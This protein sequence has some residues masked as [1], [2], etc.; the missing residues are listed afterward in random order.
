MLGRVRV[1]GRVRLLRRVVVETVVLLR[2]TGILRC[3]IRIGRGMIALVPAL[4]VSVVDSRRGRGVVEAMVT[5]RRRIMVWGVVVLST[6]RRSRMI[7]QQFIL[8]Q[9][10]V[11]STAIACFR[12][13]VKE[14]RR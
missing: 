14:F 9:G 2:I 5:A 7:D 13:G 3:K 4:V 10:W 12:L 6:F 8:G 1:L 11:V